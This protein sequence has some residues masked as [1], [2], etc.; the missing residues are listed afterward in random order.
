MVVGGE[1]GIEEGVQGD[2][3]RL[4]RRVLTTLSL[5]R[6]MK[7]AKKVKIYISSAASFQHFLDCPN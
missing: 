3:R 4:W 5:E 6:K 1:E 7:M 2:C